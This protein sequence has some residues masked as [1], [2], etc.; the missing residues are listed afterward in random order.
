MLK[1]ELFPVEGGFGYRILSDGNTIVQQDYAPDEPGFVVMTSEE[2]ASEA[3]I[4][5]ARIE[6]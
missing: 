3:Q 1:Y 4:V 5:I 6:G 2:A